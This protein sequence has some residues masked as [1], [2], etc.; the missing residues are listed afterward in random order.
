MT[1]QRYFDHTGGMNS[2]LRV[3]HIH[4]QSM[5]LASGEE[6]LVARALTEKGT[7]GFGF[8]F[9]L[10]AT[11]ARH[12]ATWDAAARERGVPLW[13]LLADEDATAVPA[14]DQGPLREHPWE[15]AW[16]ASLAAARQRDA[17]L[18]P[19]QEPGGGIDWSVEPG[20][21]ALRWLPE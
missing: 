19:S 15:R 21:V 20:F 2:P 13:K 18:A 7:Q 14:L 3:K 5:R 17:S 1:Q 8:A 11:N 6:A 4:V 10:E 16:R 9:E 12:M